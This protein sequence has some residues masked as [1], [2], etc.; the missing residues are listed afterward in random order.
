MKKF[1]SVFTFE[2]VTNTNDGQ[3]LQLKR[4]YNFHTFFDDLIDK[5]GHTLLSSDGLSLFPSPHYNGQY[6]DNGY[7][8]AVEFK[9][10]KE[11]WVRRCVVQ[12]APFSNNSGFEI[13]YLAPSFG[14]DFFP[15]HHRFVLT[16]DYKALT[17]PNLYELFTEGKLKDEL[18][19][20]RFLWEN[21]INNNFDRGVFRE[22]NKLKP[23]WD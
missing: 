12:F 7:P 21:G 22:K 19:E 14:I 6:V 5:N 8:N 17:K 9:Q 1:E 4:F 13:L 10:C 20:I 2:K 18:N 3:L 11:A 16:S 15:Q 23:F